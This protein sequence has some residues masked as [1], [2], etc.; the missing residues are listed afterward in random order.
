LTLIASFYDYIASFYDYIG[1]DAI[2]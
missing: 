1:S 2:K